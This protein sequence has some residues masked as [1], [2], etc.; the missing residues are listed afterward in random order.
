MPRV[1][2]AFHLWVAIAMAIMLRAYVS[3]GV[4]VGWCSERYIVWA[5]I[6]YFKDPQNTRYGVLLPLR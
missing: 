5:G 2:A 1:S 6:T 3:L 4:S